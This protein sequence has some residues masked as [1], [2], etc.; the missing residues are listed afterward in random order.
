MT[1]EQKEARIQT[2]RRIRADAA[3]ELETLGVPA[4]APDPA[5]PPPPKSWTGKRWAEMTLEEKVAYTG[6]KYGGGAEAA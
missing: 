5:V 3:K 4:D 1:G 6:E 2:L